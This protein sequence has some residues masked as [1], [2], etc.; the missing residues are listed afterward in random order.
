MINSF[1]LLNKIFDLLASDA[2]MCKLL[3]IKAETKGNQLLD[4]LNDKMRREYQTAEVIKAK[5]APF[6]S[7]YFMHSEKTKNNWLVNKGDLY[8]DIY[9]HN[10]YKAGL[11]SKRFRALIADNFKILM[12][13]EGQHFSGVTGVYKYR[14]IYNPLIDGE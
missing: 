3:N 10:M 14:L 13:Y 8:V 6:I 11:I 7:F 2:E 1:D 9:A 5:D 4:I 12:V